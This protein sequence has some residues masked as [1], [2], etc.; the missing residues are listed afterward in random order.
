MDLFIWVDLKTYFYWTFGPIGQTKRP[1]MHPM[2]R[3]R[4]GSGGQQPSLE[5]TNEDSP[6]NETAPFGVS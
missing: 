4:D 5:R 2:S 3:S 1:S 6:H